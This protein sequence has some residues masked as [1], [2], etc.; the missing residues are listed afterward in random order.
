M[1]SVNLVSNLGFR[2]DAVHTNTAYERMFLANIPSH[3]IGELTHPKYVVRHRDADKY[4]FEIYFGPDHAVQY[5][6]P[7]GLRYY[8]VALKYKLGQLRSNA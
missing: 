3:N 1:P 7:T 8:W 4:L 5:S 2:P 6:A